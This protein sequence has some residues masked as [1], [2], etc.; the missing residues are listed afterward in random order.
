MSARD[1][2]LG[3]DV[4]GDE[5]PQK[6]LKRHVPFSVT[7]EWTVCNVYHSAV[8]A[9][10]FRHLVLCVDSSFKTSVNYRGCHRCMF[11]TV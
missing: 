6:G 4:D 8:F 3:Y 11:S 5:L 2:F 7:L 9:I 10:P 1:T